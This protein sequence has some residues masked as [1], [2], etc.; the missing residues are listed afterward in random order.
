[1]TLR[2]F[3]T[4]RV[5]LM[6]HLMPNA[7]PIATAHPQTDETMTT[8]K[9]PEQSPVL[10]VGDDALIRR[11]VDQILALSEDDRLEVF[12]HFCHHCGRDDPRCQCWNDD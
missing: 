3:R 12:S 2:N 8:Q 9:N 10:V 11:V 1:M 7:H 5:L 4:L 6:M